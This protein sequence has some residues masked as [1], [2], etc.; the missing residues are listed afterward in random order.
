MIA[1]FSRSS[2]PIR[3]ISAEQVMRAPGTASAKIRAA[4]ISIALL[5]GLNT[6]VIAMAAMPRRRISAPMRKSSAGSS[7]ERS[8]PS[9]SQPPCARKKWLPIASRR[10]AGQSTIGG[11]HSV[12]GNPS[13]T[14]AVASTS[15]RCTTA[16]VKCVVPIITTPTDSGAM[17][18]SRSSRRSASSTPPITSAVVVALTACST[19]R[20]SIATASV[21]V[22]PTSTPIRIFSPVIRPPSPALHCEMVS[23]APRPR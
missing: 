15:R 4:S 11:R 9:Y 3:P 19:S 12:A 5:T 18:P 21:L 1:A 13:R 8:R 16:L 2:S 10:S 14:A 20:P 23:A 22:P 6:E 17:L 7:G